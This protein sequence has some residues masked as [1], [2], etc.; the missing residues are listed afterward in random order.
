MSAPRLHLHRVSKMTQYLTE[1]KGVPVEYP[2]VIASDT[3]SYPLNC[4]YHSISM[5][6]LLRLE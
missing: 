4:A 3:A 2:I 1:L 5:T 6:L